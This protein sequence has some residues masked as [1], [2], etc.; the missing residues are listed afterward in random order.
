M[1]NDSLTTEQT[2]SA[3]KELVTKFP[4]V[5]R[6]PKDPPIAGQNYGLFSFKFLPKPINGI[7]GFL[8]FRGAFSNEN[9][10]EK[11]AKYIIRTVDSKHHI[12]PY[13]QGE[14]M[15]ITTNEEFAK[16]TL[17]VSEKDEIV[18]V[19]NQRE[20]EEQKMQAKKVRDIKSREKKLIEEC[21]QKYQDKSTLEYY[22]QQIMK[23][24][25]LE[26]WLEQMRKRKRDL[27]KALNNCL[28][29]TKRIEEDC[30]DYVDKVDQ[31]IK[32]IKE[33]I[34]LDPDAPLDRPSVVAEE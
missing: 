12:W 16:E 29:E 33:G 23:K 18:N 28:E 11:H 15:P 7:Y 24:Q 1:E 27:L 20:S 9:E 17:E 32:D 6:L 2:E 14:W 8:K 4:K 5:E 19:Y 21:S 10:W 25:Q 13:R 31:M 34:G 30:P 3:F 22:A 26:G